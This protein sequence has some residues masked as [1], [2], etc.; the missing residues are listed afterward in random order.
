MLVLIC[1]VSSKVHS[2]YWVHYNWNFR[3]IAASL[4]YICHYS[5]AKFLFVCVVLGSVA[6]LLVLA[7]SFAVLL[8][9]RDGHASFLSFYASYSGWTNLLWPVV[10]LEILNSHSRNPF[11]MQ[12]MWSTSVF[13]SAVERSFLNI[14]GPCV[15]RLSTE[16][17]RYEFIASV[18]TNKLHL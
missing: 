13:L 8:S 10:F 2:F 9:A 12:W 17:V 16:A 15:L 3:Q 4:L 7:I 11:N 18:A 1:R 6:K 14:C 5:S